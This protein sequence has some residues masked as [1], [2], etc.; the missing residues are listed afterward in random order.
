MRELEFF[1]D[2]ITMNNLENPLKIE[3]IEETTKKLENFISSQ[4]HEKLRKKG[5]VIGL[6][7]GIDSSITATLSVKSLGPENVF[8]MILPE[9]ESSPQSAN[10]AKILAEKLKIE[11]ETI[12]MTPILDAFNV[13]EI[14]ENI[15]RK[16]FPSFNEECTYGLAVSTNA[17]TQGGLRIPFLQIQDKQNH[18]HK[19]RL[20][21]I[22]FSTLS[23]ATSIK[24]RTR[25]TMLYYFA[26]KYNLAVVGSTNKSEYIQGYFV[27]Y[28]D[29]GVDLEPIQNLY[30]TQIYQLGKYL[31]IP[32]EILNR[33]ASP[34][35]WSF[36]VSDEDFFYGV[37]Y[38]TLDLVWHA[39]EK[40]IPMENI[41]K[42]ID[43]EKSQIEN[44]L[45]YLKKRWNSSLHMR[46][47]PASLEL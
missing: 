29:G 1:F 10:L 8:G 24:H 14:R 44:L 40:N 37:D 2:L 38:Y 12:D 28:G 32:E 45:L 31:Q 25:M 30:K 47:V 26:E 43:L 34:D 36:E 35:T 18:I 7:G 16:Y 39:K 41:E 21:P 46:E 42:F 5:V 11:T 17:V 4:I 33:K 15:V 23:S 22:D 19:F 27:K 20:S 6:S 9:K 13:Y 3:N